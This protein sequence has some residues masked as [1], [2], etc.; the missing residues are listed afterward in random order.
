MAGEEDADGQAGREREERDEDEHSGMMGSR[1]FDVKRT[2]R[3][4]HAHAGSRGATLHSV[5]CHHLGGGTVS[6][7]G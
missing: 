4:P 3:R 1:P 2:P 7:R 5:E 6:L